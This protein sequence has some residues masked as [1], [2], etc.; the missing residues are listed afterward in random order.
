[1]SPLRQTQSKAWSSGCPLCLRVWS[2]P[3]RGIFSSKIV[4]FVSRAKM[5]FNFARPG[6][7]SPPELCSAAPEFKRDEEEKSPE[8]GL[9]KKLP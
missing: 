7:K 9:K 5:F 8:I 6:D 4:F 2:E 3:A 1:M